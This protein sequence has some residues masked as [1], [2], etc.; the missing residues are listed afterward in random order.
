LNL[1]VRG[2][3]IRIAIVLTL[4][5]C[6]GETS[7]RCLASTILKPRPRRGRSFHLACPYHNR[8]SRLFDVVRP[9]PFLVHVIAGLKRNGSRPSSITRCWPRVC[10]S[11]LHDRFGRRESGESGGIDNCRCAFLQ[12]R[13]INRRR[14]KPTERTPNGLAF[15]STELKVRSDKFPARIDKI[16]FRHC[17]WILPGVD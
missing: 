12:F 17:C 7:L 10:H 9:L 2:L 8:P 4:A 16:P 14:L 11:I 3:R 1:L 15:A 6:A 5:E 13:R